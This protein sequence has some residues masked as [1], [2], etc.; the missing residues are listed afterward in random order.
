MPT[1]LNIKILLKSVTEIRIPHKTELDQTAVNKVE[2]Q[3]GSRPA[4]NITRLKPQ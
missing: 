2:V 3:A 1:E 4:G